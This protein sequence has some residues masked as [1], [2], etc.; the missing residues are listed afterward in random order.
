VLRNKKFK[1][2]GGVKPEAGETGDGCEDSVMT[3]ISKQSD[4]EEEKEDSG[5]EDETYNEPETVS[6][7]S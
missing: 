1:A 4:D 6:W 3:A 7:H 5:H 2:V